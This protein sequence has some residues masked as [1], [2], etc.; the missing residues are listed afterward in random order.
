MCGIETHGRKTPYMER[1]FD[2]S[3]WI[4]DFLYWLNVPSK[5]WQ[6]WIYVSKWGNAFLLLFQNSYHNSND[7]EYFHDCS[8]LVWRDF[9]EQNFGVCSSIYLA[10]LFNSNRFMIY[11]ENKNYTIRLTVIPPIC[12]KMS[13]SPHN[14]L[15]GKIKHTCS[16]CYQ[17][18][19]WWESTINFPIPKFPL[20]GTAHQRN[21][22]S[23]CVAL[24]TFNLPT[25]IQPFWR[26]RPFLLC[27]ARLSICDE[28]HTDTSYSIVR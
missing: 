26:S 23:L 4:A 27:L 3:H 11:D 16:D 28:N 8:W 25:F 13:H 21:E 24:L 14:V 22:W 20:D 6:F 17:T 18:R 1:T 2:T 5:N 15:L 19:P 7:H 9:L 10:Q 12:K